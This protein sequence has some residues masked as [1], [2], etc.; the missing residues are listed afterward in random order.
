MLVVKVK[1]DRVGFGIIISLVILSTVAVFFLSYQAVGAQNNV[2]KLNNQISEK[3]SKIEK[4]Q[5]KV[6]QLQK[7]VEARRSEAVSLENQL[8]IL[9]SQVSQIETEIEINKSQIEET[10]LEVARTRAEIVQADKDI[11]ELKSKLGMF[12]REMYRMDQKGMLEI[13]LNNES[14]SVFFNEVEASE[15]TQSQLQDNLRAFKVLQQDLKKKETTLE[16]QKISLV[17]LAENLNGK[18]ELLAGQSAVRA[19]I[20]SETRNSESRFQNQLRE[21]RTEQVAISA[22]IQSLEQVIRQ[23][24]VGK[25]AETLNK[26]GGGNFMYPVPFKGITAYFHD[27]SYPYRYV[28]EHPAIDMRAGQG[29]QVSA[30]SSGFVARVR[31]PKNVGLGYAYIMLIHANGVSSVYGHLS[32]V[33]VKEDQFVSKGEI[34]ALTGGLPGTPGAG[35]LTTG[36]HIHFEVRKNGIPVNPLDYLP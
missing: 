29:T 15:R 1:N 4:L 36:P 11:G 2:D 30:A 9:G 31:D 33:M 14:I 22:E 32:K 17:A 19:N 25:G 21:A 16:K 23:R 20:L 24:L 12:I 35:R 27:P 34:I 7:S 6:K 28:F 13:L 18:Y 8:S 5:D 26:L 3:K 10:E